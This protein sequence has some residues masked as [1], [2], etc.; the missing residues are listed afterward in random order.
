M[1]KVYSILWTEAVVAA[2]AITN[3]AFINNYNR[4]FLLKSIYFDISIK[5]E[6]TDV[7][8][9]LEQNTEFEYSLKVLSQP[10]GTMIATAFE[11]CTP[12]V[13]VNSNG[14]T[15]TMY[16]PGQLRFESFF[17]VN[18]VQIILNFF[19]RAAVTC[20]YYATCIIET[21]EIKIKFAR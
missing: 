3:D 5:T 12:A 1:N 6:A 11:G 13:N 9:P 16:R 2:D 20:R 18:Q 21:E 19:N 17:N 4:N 15:I 8:K 7:I 14:K 10:V